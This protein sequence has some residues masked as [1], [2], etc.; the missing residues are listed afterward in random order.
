MYYPLPDEVD[1]LPAYELLKNKGFSVFFPVTH[2]DGMDF[3]EVRALS[4]FS[5]GR[6]GVMEPIYRDHAFVYSGRRTVCLTPGTLFSK[7]RQRKGR[8]GGYYDRFLS[9]YPDI[10]KL[11]ITDEERLVESISVNPWDVD[12]DAVITEKRII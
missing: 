6:L 8:G 7:K 4:D 11:G 5:S 2:E 1:I 12:M 9:L 10:I 3:F